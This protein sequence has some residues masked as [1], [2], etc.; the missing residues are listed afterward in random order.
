MD[1]IRRKAG[2]G[3]EPPARSTA[4]DAQLAVARATGLPDE[5]AHRLRGESAAE[6]REDAA[7]LNRAAAAS[8][9]WRNAPPP[10]PSFD[11]GARE[12]PPPEQPSMSARMCAEMELRRA[13]IFARARELDSEQS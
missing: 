5:V 11:G 4:T 3:T 12:G 13:D 8:G 6:L 2:R 9:G 7:A 1:L 10:A